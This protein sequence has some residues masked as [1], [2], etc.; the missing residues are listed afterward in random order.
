MVVDHRKHGTKGGGPPDSSYGATN[1]PHWW[2]P[3]PEI[4]VNEKK[5]RKQKAE[6]KGGGGTKRKK[7]GS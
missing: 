3:F 5:K 1:A 2:P 7:K 4:S 6:K